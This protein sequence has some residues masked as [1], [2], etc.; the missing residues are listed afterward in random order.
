MGCSRA[1]PVPAP[2][3]PRNDQSPRDPERGALHT[4]LRVHLATFVAERERLGAP[5]PRFVLE[6]LEGYLDCGRLLAG[7]ARFECEGCGLT[8]VTALSCKGR[9]LT[10][11]AF[12]ALVASVESASSADLRPLRHG[13]FHLGPA[14]AAAAG[15]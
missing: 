1:A 11:R 13:R 2:A 7:C 5:L 10:P 4:I 14:L 3:S 6:E 8:R 9:G 12:G 15:A